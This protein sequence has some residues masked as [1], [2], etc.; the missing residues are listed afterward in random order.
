MEP[1]LERITIAQFDGAAHSIAAVTELLH[2]AYGPLLAKGLRYYAATQ[3]PKGTSWRLEAGAGIVVLL[4]REI[5]GTATYYD[6]YEGDECSWYRRRE[7]GHFG[8]FAV[9]PEYQRL[10]IGTRMLGEMEAKAIA[11]GKSELALDTSEKSDD[12]IGYFAARG[13]RYIERVRWE[14]TNYASVI[15]SKRLG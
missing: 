15:M 3:S 4:G 14:L 8:Q 11:G 13:F 7:V 2:E 10:G 12:L 5:I 9:K 6:S 1:V